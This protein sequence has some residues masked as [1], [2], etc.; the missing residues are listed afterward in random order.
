MKLKDHVAAR[1]KAIRKERR[2]TQE[3]LAERIDRSVYAISQFERGISVPSFETLE[4]LSKE[5]SVPVSSFF[6]FERKEGRY[7][8]K[9]MLEEL[10]ERGKAMSD[11]DLGMAIELLKLVSFRTKT[12]RAR[13]KRG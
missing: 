5:L 2:L 10:A 6:E 11:E 13:K 1:I 12:K 4:R 3:R 7:D 9:A 8:R